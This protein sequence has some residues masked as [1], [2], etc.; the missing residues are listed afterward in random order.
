LPETLETTDKALCCQDAEVLCT[1]VQKVLRSV[2]CIVCVIILY[3]YV[4][5]LLFV[6]CNT[7]SIRRLCERLAS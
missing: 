4:M 1:G 2:M 5:R 6:L 3:L 7:Y